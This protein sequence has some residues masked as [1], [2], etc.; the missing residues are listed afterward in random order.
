M[1]YCINCWRVTLIKIDLHIHSALSACA[2]N[3]LSPQNILKQAEKNKV[4][5]IAVTDHNAIDHSILVNRLSKKSKVNT[6]LGVE[7]TAKEEVHLLGYFPNEASLKEMGKKINECLPQMKNNPSY[8]G[9]QLIYNDKGQICQIDYLLRQN[10]LQIGLDDLVTFIHLIGGIAIPAHVEREHC[11]IKSQIGFIDPDSDF[12]AIEVSKFDWIKKKFKLGDLLEGYPVLSGSD[13]HF[14]DDIGEFF[15]EV[16]DNNFIEDFKSFENFLRKI[17]I[18][19][20]C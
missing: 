6:I 2:E 10:A 5:L 15:M 4:N 1:G 3:I 7:L 18:E 16:E 14:L 9:Y 17:K 12:D 13:S 8:F 20:H 11:S 19:K